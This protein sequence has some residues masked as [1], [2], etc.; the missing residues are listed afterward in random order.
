MFVQKVNNILK[1]RGT[2]L[3]FHIIE[4]EASTM[5]KIGHDNHGYQLQVGTHK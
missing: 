3:G 2:N 5:V 1:I 4:N